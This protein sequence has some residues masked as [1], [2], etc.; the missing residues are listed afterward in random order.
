M[1]SMLGAFEGTGRGCNEKKMSGAPTV[2]ISLEQRM[3]DE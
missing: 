2:W 1:E 3:H